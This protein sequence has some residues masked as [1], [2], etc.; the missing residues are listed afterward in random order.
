MND[1]TE[2]KISPLSQK[3]ESNGKSVDVKIY[4]DGH[5]KWILEVVDEFNGSTVWED[6]FQTDQAALDEL[7]DTLK[8]DGIECLIGQAL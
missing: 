2:L 1:K 4:G 5:G 7:N 3:V 8:T 6:P